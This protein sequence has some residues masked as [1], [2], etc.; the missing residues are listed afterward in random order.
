MDN[1]YPMLREEAVI[2]VSTPCDGCFR[3]FVCE[4]LDT[5]TRK[6]LVAASRASRKISASFHKRLKG[7]ETS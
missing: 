3:I 5:A 6:K 1:I 7:R 2:E 4:R